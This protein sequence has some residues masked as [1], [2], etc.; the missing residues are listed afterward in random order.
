M[1]LKFADPRSL[2]DNS[3]KARRSRRA[4]GP[5]QGQAGL[6]RR[7]EGRAGAIGPK[8]CFHA[9]ATVETRHACAGVLNKGA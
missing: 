8:N 7:N 9:P 2:K 5:L 1:E 6:I 4:N 3:D